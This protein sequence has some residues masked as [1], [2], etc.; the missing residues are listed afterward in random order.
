MG[1]RISDEANKF[2]G[3]VIIGA[4]GR[5]FDDEDD[6][7]E[8]DDLLLLPL[9]LLPEEDEDEDE[10]DDPKTSLTRSE[11]PFSLSIGLA[12]TKPSC[13]QMPRPDG[14]IRWRG[15]QT[16]SWSGLQG[17]TCSLDWVMTEVALARSFSY[18]DGDGEDEEEDNSC[19]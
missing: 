10:E 7:E 8:D 17:R 11:K 14:T 5:S 9:L 15:E 13:S 12:M 19:C 16:R 4:G 6:E 18:D 2:L 3:S 1:G